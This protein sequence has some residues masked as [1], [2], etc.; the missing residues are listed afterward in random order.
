MELPDSQRPERVQDGIC[1][2]WRRA[3]GTGLSTALDPERVAF[4]RGLDE[5]ELQRRH[6]VGPRHCIVQER[7]AQ[8]LTIGIV[9]A[10]FHQ[11]LP[12]TLSNSAVY[13]A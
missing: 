3:C 11:R 7:S 4:C 12:K 1:N 10:V 13:L 2:R 6:V 9:D 5:V 8:K